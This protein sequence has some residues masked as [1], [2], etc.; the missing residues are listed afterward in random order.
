MNADTRFDAAPAAVALAALDWRPAMRRAAVTGLLDLMRKAPGLRV[1]AAA[2]LDEYW[3][4]VRE[5]RPMEAGRIRHE[6]AL[7]VG[8][9]LLARLEARAAR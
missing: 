8:P 6:V 3:D 9:Y 5:V 2:L 1:Q 7:I 4:V